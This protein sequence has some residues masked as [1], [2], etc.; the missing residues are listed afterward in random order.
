ML[1]GRKEDATTYPTESKKEPA[2]SN[3][4]GAVFA[5]DDEEDDLPF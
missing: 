1:G 4:Q 2:Q 5:A 3:D